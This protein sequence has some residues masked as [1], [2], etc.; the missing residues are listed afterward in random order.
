V[1]VSDWLWLKSGHSLARYAPM[2]LAIQAALFVVGTFFWIDANLGQGGNFRLGTWGS[3]A[4]AIPAE[5][6]AGVN[7][8]ASAITFVGL[9]HPI[10]RHLAGVGA[11]LHCTQF[12]VIAYSAVATGG[13]LEVG[14]YAGILL[15]PLH[16][17]IVWKVAVNELY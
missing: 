12:L 1:S 7:M 5:F 15:L 13:E 4:Y 17:W 2:L 6:W 16:M 11:A 10:K 9:M 8:L 3:L 14:L